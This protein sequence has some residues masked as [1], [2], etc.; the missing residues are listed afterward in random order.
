ML[1][2]ARPYAASRDDLPDIDVFIFDIIIKSAFVA[3][4]RQCFT[5]VFPSDETGL[6]ASDRFTV[7]IHRTDG[8]AGYLYLSDTGASS[9]EFRSSR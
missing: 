3:R 5:D 6:I 4:A 8:A 1:S 9:R 2:A 7:M